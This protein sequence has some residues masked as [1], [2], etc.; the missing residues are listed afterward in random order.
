[1]AQII[2]VK[3]GGGEVKHTEL[4]DFKTRR[5]NGKGFRVLGSGWEGKCV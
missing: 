4:N 1:M 2:C 3:M 5:G